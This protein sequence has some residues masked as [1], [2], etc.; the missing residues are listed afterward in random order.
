MQTFMPYPD[1]EASAACL[2][3]KRLGNQCYREGLTLVTGGWSNHPAAKMWYGY[4]YALCK[5]CEACA[6]EMSRRGGW[7]PGIA[8][9]W[10]MHF[11]KLAETFA[12]T[13]MPPWMGD[14]RVHRSHRA[15]LKRKDPEYYSQFTEEPQEGYYWPV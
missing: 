14:E 9:K 6:E 4:E 13:G 1:F 15:N 11:Q 10:V 7:K 5:Y 3:S 2:D 8:D 12:D